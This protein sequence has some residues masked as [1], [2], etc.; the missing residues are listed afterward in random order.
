MSPR[1]DKI[2]PGDYADPI[3]GTLLSAKE[4]A[5]VNQYLKE[6]LEENLD[7][8][9]KKPRIKKLS[10]PLPAKPAR[11]GKPAK[12]A[13]PNVYTLKDGTTFQLRRSVIIDNKGNKVALY[14]GKEQALG[15]GAYGIVKLG[16]NIDTNELVA[17][18]RQSTKDVSDQ[19][20]K[21]EPK[22]QD[23][24][25][26]TYLRE[27]RIETTVGSA[28]DHGRLIRTKKNKGY[29]IMKLGGKSLWDQI[30]TLKDFDLRHQTA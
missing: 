9:H 1:H 21:K 23:R 11:P 10:R 24:F 2:L 12:P 5:F 14:K 6:K 27:S 15:K 13:R 29:I 18:K 30:S 28:K 19:S 20:P 3:L 16:Q 8:K 7:K 26:K 17:V 4:V 22:K 25:M